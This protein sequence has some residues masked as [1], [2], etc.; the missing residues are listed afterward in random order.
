MERFLFS[1]VPTWVLILTFLLSILGMV[2][3]GMLT[4][5]H[6]NGPQRFGVLS[7]IAGFISG[8]PEETWQSMRRGN[9]MRAVRED[10]F[11][12]RSGWTIED[13]ASSESY[14]L[15]SRHDGEIGVHAV[16]LV[17]LTTFEVLHRWQPDA[18]VLFEGVEHDEDASLFANWTPDLFRA[19]H[20]MPLADGS[21]LIKDHASPL[22][23]IDACGR[24]I[25][26]NTDNTFHHST[27]QAIDGT[28]WVAGR[29]NPLEL[30]VQASD[31]YLDDS[32]VRVTADGEILENISLT[33]AFI[34]QGLMPH[35]LGDV[36]GRQILDPIHLNDIQ[37]VPSDGPYWKAGDVFLSMRHMSMV[38]LFRPSTREVVWARR[39]PWMAQH[40]VDIL[41][42][43][44]ISIYSN[45]S[46]NL[47]A[48]GFVYGSNEVMIYDFETDTTTSPFKAVSEALEIT[49][50]SESLSEM[51]PG[52]KVL[53]EEENSGRI[54]ILSPGGDLLAE[55]VNRASDGA[56]YRLGWSRVLSRED[57]DVLRDALSRAS[58]T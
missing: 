44:R 52:G 46:Y 31:G 10:R 4:Y 6:Y 14:L 33:E 29:A 37:P 54:L 38:V 15:L 43:T 40:D 48:G 13:G 7:R 58:C 8:A 19:I 57:G 2:G 18:H 1:K 49:S 36:F 9:P 26:R 50:S 41:D 35:F 30:D 21:L 24:Q 25:W 22:F 23:R 53:I 47:G 27:E 16:E 28:Y 5:D 45:N 39:G 42:D 11:E 17:D 55:F 12:D 56:I 32:L 34:D 3:F 51:L 20:P